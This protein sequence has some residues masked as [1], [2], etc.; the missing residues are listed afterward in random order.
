MRTKIWAS[1]IGRYQG[2]PEGDLFD[3]EYWSLEQA[4][5]G[6]GERRRSRVRS[7]WSRAAR[8]RSARAWRASSRAGAQV[9]LVDVDEERLLATRARVG[10]SCE[11]FR[12]DVS[13]EG[14]VRDAFR[15]AAALWGGVDLVVVNAGIARAGALADL[16]LEDFEA[17]IDVNLKGAFIT[18][19]EALFHMRLQGTGGNVVVVST[20]NVFAPGAGVRRTARRRPA[21]TSCARGCARGRGFRRAREP[22]E[23][24]RRLRRAGESSGL[25]GKSARTRQS[26]RARAPKISRRSTATATC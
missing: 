13:D 26:A 14:D 5:L 21:R 22:G 18:L 24:R 8:E 11:A 6:K 7:R 25:G 19:R 3:I 10:P 12:A 2:L 9:L 23:R 16:A 1:A 17:T 4:K 15:H 20:K